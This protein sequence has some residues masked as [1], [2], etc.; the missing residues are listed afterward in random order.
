MV[1]VVIIEDI[2]EIREG[3]QMLIDSSDGFSCV[4]TFSNAEQ[5]IENLPG[6]CPDVALMDIN[7][8]AS[9]ASKLFEN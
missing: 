8:P 7:L 6:T 3:L 4:R 2:K 5:A 1:H 9:T